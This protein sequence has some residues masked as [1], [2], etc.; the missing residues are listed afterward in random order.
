VVASRVKPVFTDLTVTLAPE[1]TAPVGSL[2]VPLIWPSSV[3]PKAN[4]EESASTKKTIGSLYFM[5]VL[6]VENAILIIGIESLS[7]IRKRADRSPMH[8]YT[9]QKR[10]AIL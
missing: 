5:E 4:T 6:L 3:W 7:K 1:T 2:T 9:Q 8:T 10:G